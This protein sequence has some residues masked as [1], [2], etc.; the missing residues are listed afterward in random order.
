M[1]T[2]NPATVTKAK[3]TAS[4]DFYLVQPLTNNIIQNYY[5]YKASL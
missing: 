2:I 1:L 5:W 3:N 4:N